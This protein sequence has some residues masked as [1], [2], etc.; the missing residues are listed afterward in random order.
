M[1]MLRNVI[2]VFST[3]EVFHAKTLADGHKKNRRKSNKILISVNIVESNKRCAV[4]KKM[5]SS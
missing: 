2:G 4:T 1:G 3:F 5:A